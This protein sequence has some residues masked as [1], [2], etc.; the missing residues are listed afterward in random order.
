MKISWLQ[1]GVLAL[2]G[3]GFL[4]FFLNWNLKFLPQILGHR[5]NGHN[6]SQNASLPKGQTSISLL[7]ISS[8]FKNFIPMKKS[9]W[10]QKQHQMFQELD[11]LRLQGATVYVPPQTCNLTGLETEIPDIHSYSETHRDFV[12]YIN[13]RDHLQKINH[14]DK[15]SDGVFLLLAVKSTAANFERRQA[16][17]ETWGKELTLEDIRVRTVFLVGSAFN[18]GQGP[19]LQRLLNSE[20][21]LYGDILQWEFKDSLFNLTLK[22]YLF[23]KW[24]TAHCPSAQYIFKGDDDIFLNTPVILEY[25][26]SL[27]KNQSKQLYVG[28]TIREA[29]PLRDAKSKYSIPMSFYDGAYPPYA[30]GGGFLYSGSLVGSL[31]AVSHYIPFY[32]IDDVFT[33]MCFS[34]LGISPLHHQGFQTFDIEAKHRNDPCAHRRLILVHQRSPLQ[35]MQLWKALHS[36]ELQC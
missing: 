1:I 28:Q 22:D 32:P 3:F 6:S 21:H 10:N 26:Q 9:F 11:K 13:C 14:S 16:I 5:A 35:T 33:G 4:N 30:G 27:D 12:R 23:L 25:L 19:D 29:T 18:L 15:C 17:R 34:A 24:A 8:A 20:D 31:Y 2:T 36:P 7:S